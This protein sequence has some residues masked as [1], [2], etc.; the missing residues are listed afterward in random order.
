[1]LM[2]MRDNLKRLWL[3]HPNFKK[4]LTDTT[5]QAHHLSILQS[6]VDLQVSE[7]ALFLFE[8]TSLQTNCVASV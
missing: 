1:M 3:Y 8:H 4:F 2:A 6:C 7:E 5:E